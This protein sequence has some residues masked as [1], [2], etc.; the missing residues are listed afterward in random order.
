[1]FTVIKQ[2]VSGCKKKMAHT[3]GVTISITF[4][5]TKLKIVRYSSFCNNKDLL[6][7]KINLAYNRFCVCVCV[8]GVEIA[9]NSVKEGW[10]VYHTCDLLW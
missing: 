10:N 9:Y 2:Y 3:W 5:G 4:W 1:M 6:L 8:G 7:W